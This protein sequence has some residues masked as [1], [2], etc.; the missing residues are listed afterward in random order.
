M[1]DLFDEKEIASSGAFGWGM[2]MGGIEVVDASNYLVVSEQKIG[3]GSK[4]KDK[5][6]LPMMMR[7]IHL[8]TATLATR[9]V[10]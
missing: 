3:N 2:M 6:P 10:T 7:R 5:Q 4:G 8:G 1:K 9:R